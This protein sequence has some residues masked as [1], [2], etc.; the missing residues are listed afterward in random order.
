[1][2]SNKMIM[3]IE[4]QLKVYRKEEKRKQRSCKRKLKDK[5]Y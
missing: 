2:S 4:N 5:I 1:M 3:Q